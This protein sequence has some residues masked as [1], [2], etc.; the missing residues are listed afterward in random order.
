[1]SLARVDANAS[2][3]LDVIDRLRSSLRA[4]DD[5]RKDER[6]RADEYRR[7]ELK[8]QTNAWMLRRRKV[9]KKS[10]SESKRA[11]LMSLFN[12]LD[13]DGG[14]EV[15]FEE[16][17][18][19]WSMMA[20]RDAA[21]MRAARAVFNDIDV[22][23]SGTMDFEEF[24]KLMN[25]L[26]YDKASSD[27]VGGGAAS[28]ESTGTMLANAS[29]ALQTRKA[30]TDFMKQ[31][32]R[33]N[34]ST[35]ASARG[36]FQTSKLSAQTTNTAWSKQRFARSTSP[37]LLPPLDERAEPSFAIAAAAARRHSLNPRSS[38]SSMDETIACCDQ[39]LLVAREKRIE[40]RGKRAC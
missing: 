2:N 20:G 5:R 11:Q 13:S 34:A 10:L 31:W 14:G 8:S 25:D 15:D 27:A 24:V 19:A 12:V 38:S 7:R 21:S 1:M 26:E 6:H 29:R 36:G 35:P 33:T 3:V 16:F 17:A 9:M 22:D 4:L 23:G 28:M 40:R 30:V 37:F 32:A 39:I 18:Q